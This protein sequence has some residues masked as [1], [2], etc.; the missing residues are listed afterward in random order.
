[1]DIINEIPLR[2]FAETD[3]LLAFISIY[4]DQRRLQSYRRLLHKNRSAIRHAVC[5]DAGCGLGYLSEE[6]VRLGAARVYAVESN[7]LLYEE[8][9]KR[10]ADL[11]PVVLI[12][13]D[14]RHFK[15]RERVDVL[16]HEFF[17]QMLFDEDISV[18][19]KLRFKPRC[20]LPNSA[21]LMAGLTTLRKV[22]DDNVT[23]DLL[24][25]L[26]GVLVSGLFE[27]RQMPLQF[28]VIQW[29]PD[30]SAAKIKCDLSGRKGEVLYFGL[31]VLHNDRLICQAV[32]CD[33]WSF[34]WTPRCGD[35]F[36]LL[37]LPD[38]RGTRVKFRWLK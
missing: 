20:F 23:P 29:Q 18:L 9:K 11:K 36:E 6:L 35:K 14:L 3:D 13:K 2:R 16:V 27:D 17:G 21:R 33:N 37:F 10:L 38:R 25:K 28:P 12:K 15:P 22:C 7:S 19:G 31:Q 5:V 34:V 24:Q 32:E 26:Q 8:A 4:D 1:M 30:S